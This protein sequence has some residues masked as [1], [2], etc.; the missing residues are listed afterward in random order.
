MEI[1]LKQ[2]YDVEVKLEGDIKIDQ[3]ESI[4]NKYPE[5]IQFKRDI[6]LELL[7]KEGKK[8]QYDVEDLNP[9]IYMASSEKLTEDIS[10][11]IKSMSFIISSSKV[12]SLTLKIKILPTHNGMILYESIKNTG[13]E[14]LNVKIHQHIIDNK[15]IYFYIK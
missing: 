7:L 11:V 14:F 12:E 15:I 6:K 10:S 1:N 3:Y 13:I 2:T 8:V 9:P 5:W 4:L